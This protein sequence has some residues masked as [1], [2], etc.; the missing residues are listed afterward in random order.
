MS[1]PARGENRKQWLASFPEMNPNPV[2]EINAQGE[3]TFANPATLKILNDLGFPQNPEFFVPDDI[4]EIL[5]MLSDPTA[6]QIY[7][8]INLNNA[9]FSENIALNCE[10]Q[11]VR[12]YT[13]DITWRKRMEEELRRAY[14]HTSTILESISDSFIVLDK[15]WRFTYINRETERLW[16]KDRGELIGRN[17][18]EVVP[19][20]VRKVSE[21]AGGKPV[22]LVGWCLGGLIALADEHGYYQWQEGA[23][24]MLRAS[25][26]RPEDAGGR[27]A[28]EHPFRVAGIGENRMQAQAAPAWL[29]AS[30]TFDRIHP[31][32]TERFPLEERLIDG[33]LDL[34]HQRMYGAWGLFGFVDYNAGPVLDYLDGEV[35]RLYRFVR[36]TYSLRSDLWLQYARSGDRRTREFAAATNRTYVDN[37]Y[38]HWTYKKKVAGLPVG[39]G[40]GDECHMAFHFPLMPRMFSPATAQM[41]A[42]TSMV[43]SG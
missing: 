16:K 32:D 38:S 11:V 37:V 40:D 18:W 33:T 41:I 15:N 24:Q 17:I 36:Y 14:D 13:T 10:L 25:V 27:D 26:A 21:D 12:I 7:R 20:A 39:S 30:G 35:P 5:T 19:N 34:W 4:E 6:H 9:W 22:H 8:E 31:R 29:C 42:S 3:I 28:D 23:I 43:N 2:I 1:E